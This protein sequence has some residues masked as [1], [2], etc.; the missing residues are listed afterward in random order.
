MPEPKRGPFVHKFETQK[1]KYVFDVNSLNIVCVDPVVWDIIEDV[2]RFELPEIVVRHAARWKEEQIRVAHQEIL[3]SQQKSGLFVMTRPN[4]DFY[5]S[6]EDLKA[7]YAHNRN[8]LILNVTERCNF[9]CVYCSNNQRNRTME[10]SQPDVSWEVAKKAID[11][12]LLDASPT[13]TAVTFYG[14][15][16]LLNFDL[17]RRC[18]NYIRQL[19]GGD[20]VFLAVT[21]NGS[22]LTDEKTDFLAAQSVSITVSLDGPRELHDRY[23]RTKKGEPTW[24]TIMA[25]IERYIQRHR[26]HLDSGRFGLSVVMTAPMDIAQLQDFFASFRVNAQRIITLNFMDNRESSFVPPGRIEG[27]DALRRTFM[28]N[29][30]SGILNEDP[31]NIRHRIARLL[32]EQKCLFL[33]RRHEFHGAHWTDGHIGL[34]AR[35]FATASCLPGTRRTF[36][37]S[38]GDLWPCERTRHT[39]FLKIGDI[40]QGL[41]LAAIREK[42]ADWV[43]LTREEC[44]D[45]WCL[46]GCQVGCF[47]DVSFGEKPTREQKLGACERYRRVCHDDLVEYCSLLEDNPHALDYLKEVIVG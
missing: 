4:V 44:Q 32:Y 7:R 37:N 33:H 17:I 41:N 46:H 9:A 2:G 27:L 16:P 29:V 3:A 11:Q 42:L 47:A 39:E 35:Y 24:D 18:V 14:G 23:R 34:P 40:Y 45:C 25:N 5:W 12:F 28:E 1:Q 30:R 43:A 8:I 13:H 22:L 6:I 38:D 19:D 10:T 36:V 20:K 15:E 26:P 21:T 31:F